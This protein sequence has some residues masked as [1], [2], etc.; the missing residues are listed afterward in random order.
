MVDNHVTDLLDIVHTDH[1]LCP[2]QH[3][4]IGWL[5]TPLRVEEGLVHDDI[6]LKEV[7]D[8]GIELHAA[9]LLVEELPGSREAPYPVPEPCKGNIALVL[10]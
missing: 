7:D 3:A 10:P 9:G 6:S 1:A 2:D 4:G 8:H 5:A